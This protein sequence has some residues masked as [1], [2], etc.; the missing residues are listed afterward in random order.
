MASLSSLDE[1]QIYYSL[2]C[3]V[4]RAGSQRH[5][6]LVLVEFVDVY[7]DSVRHF[8]LVDLLDGHRGVAVDELVSERSIFRDAVRALAICARMQFR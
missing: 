1:Q 2:G 8:E 6:A 7:G 4:E 3:G 5:H